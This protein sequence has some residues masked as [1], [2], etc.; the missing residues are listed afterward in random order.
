MKST[1]TYKSLAELSSDSLS[2]VT[3]ETEKTKLPEPHVLKEVPPKIPHESLS[4]VSEVR[5]YER[6]G[7][8]E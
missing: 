8:N 4:R 6:W 2:A 1:K 3:A 5:G 7:I